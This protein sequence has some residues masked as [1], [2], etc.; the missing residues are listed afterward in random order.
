MLAMLVCGFNW[1]VCCD[2]S[3]MNRV[4]HVRGTGNY[5]YEGDNCDITVVTKAGAIMTAQL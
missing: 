3:K 1:D 2:I 5:H 4:S